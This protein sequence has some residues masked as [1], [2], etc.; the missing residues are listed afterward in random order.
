MPIRPIDLIFNEGHDT[1][2]TL[3][4]KLLPEANELECVVAFAKMSGLKP[5]LRDLKEALARGLKARFTLGLSF[6]QTE[7]S[8][9][10][11]LFDLAITQQLTL[12]LSGK[13]PTFHPK[14]YS[15]KHGTRCTVIVGSSNLTSG[16]LQA[17]YEASTVLRSSDDK[18][19]AQ[20]S[21]Y[22]QGLIKRGEVSAAT[23]DMI[24]DYRREFDIKRIHQA[25]ADSAA[26]A[27]MK[28]HDTNVVTLQV[29]LRQMKADKTD[30]GFDKMVAKRR[31]NQKLA[32]NA[33]AKLAASKPRTEVAFQAAYEGL[34]ERFH[35]GGLHRGKPGVVENY[36]QFL[37]GIRAALSLKRTAPADAFD[38]LMDQFKNVNGAGVNLLTEILMALNSKRF[39]NMNQAAIHGMTLANVL[40]FPRH[41]SKGS[42]H[43]EKYARYCSE[44]DKVRKSLKLVDFVEL[45]ALFNY[46]YR[47]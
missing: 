40:G 25:E 21:S 15:L 17:N 43:G 30:R 42:V 39:A 10:Q 5:L 18:V 47:P 46:A 27:A 44:A 37:P 14:I 8:L 9:L 16:G 36:R 22:V 41:P 45:D 38:T 29:L 32:Q 13:N 2:L 23:Q 7:P 1:H 24:D 3:L 34:L 26:R 11:E 33:I 20:I 35:S 12:Y 4:L 19:A 6:Y 28:R 31:R